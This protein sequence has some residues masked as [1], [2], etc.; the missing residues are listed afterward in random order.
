[1]V[2]GGVQGAFLGINGLFAA[3]RDY[4]SLRRLLKKALAVSCGSDKP[5][6]DTSII[7]DQDD[8]TLLFKDDGKPFD[9]VHVAEE[10][11]KAGQK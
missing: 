8:I 2:S 11:R 7:C 4:D 5:Y 3:Q 1:M 6:A 9:T 10:N